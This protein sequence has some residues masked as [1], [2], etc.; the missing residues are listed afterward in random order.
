MLGDMKEK[1]TAQY[2]PTFGTLVP[3][4]LHN[5]YPPSPNPLLNISYSTYFTSEQF[6]VEMLF[7]VM[8]LELW[9]MTEHGLADPAVNVPPLL[10]LMSTDMTLE[11]RLTRED[12]GANLWRKV[13]SI[14]AF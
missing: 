5:I 13:L 7:S 14:I 1:K 11:A 10:V 4:K 8:F 12:L 2:Q 9:A 6:L 3:Q